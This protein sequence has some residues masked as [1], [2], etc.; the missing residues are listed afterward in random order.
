MKKKIVKCIGISTI[1]LSLILSSSTFKVEASDISMKTLNKYNSQEQIL[2][3]DKPIQI[4]VDNIEQEEQFRGVWVSTVFNLDLPSKKGLAQEEY[5]REYIELLDNLQ[6]LNINSVIFQVRP[7]LDAFYK[8]KINPWSEFLTGTQGLSPGW[9]PLKWMIEETHNR[10]MEF[11]AWFNPYRVT[12][13]SNNKKTVKQQLE[14]LAPNNWARQNPQYVFS[15]DGKLYLNPGEP[16][17][18]KYIIESVMEVVKNYDIDAVHFDDY[19]YPYRSTKDKDKWYSIEEQKTFAKYGSGFK[20]VADWR[21]DNVDKLILS[22]HNSIT[23]YNKEQKKSVQF[24]ISPYGIWG[25]KEIHPEGS[26]AGTGSLT[27]ITSQASYD[28]LFADTRKWVKNNWIDYI[29]PQ[30]YWSFDEKAAPYGELVNWWADVVKDTNVHLYIGH[31]N[32]KKADINN[33]NISWKNPEEISNQLKFNS[34]YKEVKGSI[35][36]RYKSLLKT[37]NSAKANNEFIDILKNQHFNTISLLPSKP[38]LDHKETLSPYDLSVV[39]ENNGNRL[40]WYDTIDNDSAY[41]VICR[42]EVVK[43]NN[44]MGQSKTIISKIKRTDKSTSFTFVDT[45]IDPQ[46]EY[47]YSVAAVDKANNQSI[48]CKEK[49]L[50]QEESR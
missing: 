39:K 46:K 12:T 10:G 4:P 3:R 5:K 17:V 18:I 1:S 16:E 43:D 7:K 2:L 9:D 48:L 45:H 21:R 29:A 44:T 35:F 15:F 47:I 32:Y 6:A 19:F 37:E 23:S 8:S 33:K 34:L 49:K 50:S 38:W 30:I 40:T 14:E 31:A 42:E 41:Y 25:H 20:S 36:F 11:Q 24:G 26:E 22:L 13:T 28:N 27:P